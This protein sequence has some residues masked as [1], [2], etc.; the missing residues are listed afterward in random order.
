[1]YYWKENNVYYHRN[2]TLTLNNSRAR[3]R[4]GLVD[5]ADLVGLVGLICLSGPVWWIRIKLADLARSCLILLKTFEG[6]SGWAL[7]QKIEQFAVRRK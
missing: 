7:G 3:L 6:S 1:M 5:L 4:K 2:P